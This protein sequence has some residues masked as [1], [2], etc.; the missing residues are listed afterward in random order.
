MILPRIIG[1]MKDYY[2]EVLLIIIGWMHFLKTLFGT[3]THTRT[4]TQNRIHFET[5]LGP[6]RTHSIL[7]S[8]CVRVEGMAPELGFQ[9]AGINLLWISL[10][11][12][13]VVYFGQLSYP[14][15]YRLIC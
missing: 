10:V 6:N 7:R 15:G 13:V 4:Q 8:D 1:V 2:L 9:R 3:D 11:F 12:F 14:G 5:D